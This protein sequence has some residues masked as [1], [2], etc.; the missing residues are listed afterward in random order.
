M[1]ETAK[2]ELKPDMNQKQIAIA[3]AKANWTYIQ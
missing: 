2:N 3:H 1:L